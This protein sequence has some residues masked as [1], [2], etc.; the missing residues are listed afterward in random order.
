MLCAAALAVGAYATAAVDPGAFTSAQRSAATVSGQVGGEGD[1][2][3][4]P[5]VDESAQTTTG[6][7]ISLWAT[8]QSVDWRFWTMVADHDG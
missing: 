7:P 4:C 3:M 5:T 8:G 2:G 1:D 6:R